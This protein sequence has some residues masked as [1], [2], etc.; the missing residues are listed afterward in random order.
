MRRLLSVLV[1]IVALAYPLIIYF[2]M[3]VF[4]PRFLALA[5][6]VLLCLRLF[7]LV[8]GRLRL[9]AWGLVGVFSCVAGFSIIE[10]D[11]VPLKF[12]PVLI[13]GFMFILFA[14]SLRFP[15]SAV[16]RLARL[17]HP[18]LPPSGVIYTQRVTQVWC[19]F[20]VFNSA[21]AFYTAVFASMK[22]WVLYNGLI[23]YVL[24]GLMFGIE[25]LVRQR[26]LAR[27][28]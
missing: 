17:T 12:Y 18:D 19:F 3:Q 8:G 21:V 14:Y 24:M 9:Q 25:W 27:K 5:L 16:E 4:E 13:N 2:G 22:T 1:A 10:N 7:L 28:I 11:V 23:A 6:V 26:I 15:P 20:F